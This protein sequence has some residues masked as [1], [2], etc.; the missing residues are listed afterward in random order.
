MVSSI[1][2]LDSKLITARSALLVLSLAFASTAIAHGH[3]PNA[4]ACK[5]KFNE[6]SGHYK[7]ECKGHGYKYEYKVNRHG[8]KEEVKGHPP[9]WMRSHARDHYARHVHPS[10]SHHVDDRVYW[11]DDLP[12]PE[13]VTYVECNREL[14]GGII[15]G[16][17][18]GALGSTVGKGDGRRAATIGGALIGVLIGSSIG[19]SVD[20][21]DA[22]CTGQVLEHAFDGQTVAWTGAEG[23]HY[24]ITPLRT[25]ERTSGTTCREFE[26]QTFESGQPRRTQ[27]TAC[28]NKVGHWEPVA[29]AT[30][31]TRR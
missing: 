2:N 19:R 5:E 25:F 10:D 20:R 12:S 9:R 11:P 22:R 4:D 30:T 28:R 27:S 17:A 23:E 7:F 3:H 26:R 8:F 31:L 14:I 29:V 15:G 13:Y 21:A 18:G 24:T 1:G 16:I 6:K